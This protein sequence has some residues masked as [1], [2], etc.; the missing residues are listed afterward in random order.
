[1]L[2]YRFL[3]LAL[4]TLTIQHVY[5]LSSILLAKDKEAKVQIVLPVNASVSERFAA[6]ELASYLEKISRA[7]FKIII[8]PNN[9]NKPSIFIKT[10]S[11]TKKE[12]YQITC[13]NGNITLS[14]NEGRTVLYAVYDFLTRLGCRW[15]AP[16]F[17]FYNGNAE[18]IPYEQNLLYKDTPGLKESATFAYRKIDIEEGL[19]HTVQN[20]KQL[21]DWM[22]KLKFN[23]LMVPSDYQGKGKVK[24]DN[25]RKELIPELKKRG[26]LIEVGGHGYQNFINPSMEG[27]TLLQKHP[28]WF[29]K[30]KEC[31]PDKDEK[32]VFNTENQDAVN[33]FIK[34]VLKYVQEHPEID[35]FDLWPPDGAKWAECPSFIAFGSPEDRQARLLNKVDSAIK[36]YRK[37]LRLQIIAYAKAIQPPANVTISKDILVD[38]CPID[39]NFESQIYDTL[40]TINVEYANVLKLWRAKFSGD[41]TLYSYFRKYGW[42]SLPNV[43]PHYIKKDMEWYA[44][45]PLQGVLTYAE[46]GDWYTYELNHYIMGNL[47]WNINADVDLLIQEYCKA[48]YGKKWQLA[49]ETYKILE[50][51]VRIYGNIRF[52]SL[53]SP[54][55]TAIAISKINNQIAEINQSKIAVSAIALANFERLSLMLQYAKYDLE[56]RSALAK[57]VPR[58][59]IYEMV[60]KMREFILQH[61]DKGT[62]IVAYGIDATE[63]LMKNYNWNSKLT[64]SD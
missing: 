2:L 14:G 30:N 8:A 17:S 62:F 10:T 48:R 6:E 54:E 55:E 50:N 32:L 20:L 43:I 38:F 28:E 13:A 64:R 7:K 53:K 24:W 19:S 41:I 22:P 35:I 46:P 23:T 25:W 26:I 34:N 63:K 36:T 4:F 3:I 1:M 16:D 52:T 31:L 11:S 27:G 60:D 9:K 61:K 45:I 29:G 15:I 42:K 47:G 49:K 59:T 58:K 5:G 18:Y 44:K 56:I 40:S 39:Q 51:T 21:I 37:D 57:N 12:T 33:Y